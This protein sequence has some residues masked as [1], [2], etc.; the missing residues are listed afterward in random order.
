MRLGW[1]TTGLVLKQH[2]SVM[3]RGPTI[4][5]FQFIPQVYLWAFQIKYLDGLPTSRLRRISSQA[6]NPG[7]A[8]ITDTRKGDSRNTAVLD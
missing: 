8:K 7:S 3:K 4:E 1:F 5:V 6:P 2:R